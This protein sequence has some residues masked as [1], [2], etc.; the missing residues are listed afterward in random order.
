VWW[1]GHGFQVVPE[2]M[3]ADPCVT[4]FGTIDVDIRDADLVK[5]I[6]TVSTFSSRVLFFQTCASGGII[7]DFNSDQNLINN[8]VIMTSTDCSDFSYDEFYEEKMFSSFWTWMT[9]WFYWRFIKN[10]IFIEHI[11]HSPF[12]YHLASAIRGKTPDGTFLFINPDSNN[13]NKVSIAECFKYVCD[14]LNDESDAYHNQYGHRLSNPQLDDHS[15][16]AP[17][18]SPF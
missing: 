10:K 9:W 11:A 1:N 2:S 12:N 13:D 14:R 4:D 3:D 18:L 7:N 15:G 8:T 6:N 16:I 17:S 5:I